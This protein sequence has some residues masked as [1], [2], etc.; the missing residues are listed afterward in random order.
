[1]ALFL[2]TS[3]NKIDKKGR[4]SVPAGFRAA[5]EGDEFSGVVLIPSQNHACLEG[6]PYAAMQEIA[7]RLDN[8]DMFSSDQDDLA[9]S[10]FGEAVQLAFDGEG[11]IMLGADLMAKANLS[12]QAVFVGMGAKFQIW[13]PDRYEERRRAARDNVTKNKLTLPKGGAA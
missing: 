6:F 10:L 9:T 13:S 4:V 2:S 5:L 3:V 1:M 12:E 11:R 7:G 8:F